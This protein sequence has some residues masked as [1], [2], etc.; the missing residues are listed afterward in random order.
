MKLNSSEAWAINWFKLTDKLQDSAQLDILVSITKSEIGRVNLRKRRLWLW[1]KQ[2]AIY[3]GADCWKKKRKRASHLLMLEDKKSG[4]HKWRMKGNEDEGEGWSWKVRERDKHQKIEID[5]LL[6]AFNLMAGVNGADRTIAS[7]TWACAHRWR[8]DGKNQDDI[9]SITRGWKAGDSN[10]P[11]QTRQTDHK[12]LAP[13]GNAH[14]TPYLA[15]PPFGVIRYRARG[16]ANIYLPSTG[17]GESLYDH[18][19]FNVLLNGYWQVLA[20]VDFY[21]PTYDESLWKS[22]I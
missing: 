22:L 20:S 2:W 10:H 11:P 21:L 17:R 5:G 3:C 14:I 6:C 15:P 16:G 18:S 8:Q 12:L 19:Q 13:A 4:R 7:D 9:W 1:Y